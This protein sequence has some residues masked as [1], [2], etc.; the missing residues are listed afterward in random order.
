LLLVVQFSGLKLLGERINLPLQV[1]DFVLS[2][3]ELGLHLGVG[4]LHFS[5]SE[6]CGLHT[7]DGH[8]GLREASL[9]NNEKCRTD[10]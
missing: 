1:L 2:R 9:R 8:F 4:F 10:Q 6:D 7:D 3:F 5:R